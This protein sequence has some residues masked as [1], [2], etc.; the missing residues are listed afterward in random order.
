MHVLKFALLL[1]NRTL[2]VTEA[3]LLIELYLLARL[4]FF[5][6]APLSQ[7]QALTHGLIVLLVIF[8]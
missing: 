5:G 2:H 4:D 3:L 1:L 8:I 7:D 6:Q